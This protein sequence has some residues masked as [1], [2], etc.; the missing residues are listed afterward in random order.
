M[1]HG[2]RKCCIKKLEGAKFSSTHQ[3]CR[4]FKERKKTKR[5]KKST[6]LSIFFLER[7]LAMLNTNP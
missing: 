6:G 7:K 1:Y 5:F 2:A 3:D 4:L